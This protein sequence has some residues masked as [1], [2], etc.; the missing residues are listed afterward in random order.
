MSKGKLQSCDHQLQDKKQQTVVNNDSGQIMEM[1]N[2]E[3]DEL[4]PGSSCPDLFPKHLQQEINE[5]ND[6]ISDNV[7]TAVYKCGFTDSQ[8][9]AHHDMHLTQDVICSRYGLG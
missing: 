8:V 9:C 7:N 5:L 3:F 4:C 6:Y 2:S 1:L